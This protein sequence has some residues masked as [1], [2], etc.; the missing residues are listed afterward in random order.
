MVFHY[1]ELPLSVGLLLSV[2]VLY[3]A[4]LLALGLA[5]LLIDRKV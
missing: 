2:P 5:K 4:T 3:T 1:K